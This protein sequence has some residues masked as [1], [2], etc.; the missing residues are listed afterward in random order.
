MRTRRGAASVFALTATV[1]ALTACAPAGGAAV[2]LPPENAV[3]DYQLGAAYEPPDG[4]TVVARDRTADPADGVYSICYLNA[5]QTQ[6]G[7]LADWPG[8][9]ILR[10][11][12]GPLFDPD[13]PGEALLD[14]ST[15]TK[16]QA[17]AD[18]VVPWIRDCAEAGFDAVEFDNLDTYT[19]S[20]G[21]LTFGDN[22]ALGRVLVGA[23]HEA[24]LAA[25]QKNAAEDARV[26]RDEGR[27][28]FAISEECAAYDEC[29]AYLDVYGE[30]VVNVEYGDP[31]AFA[32]ACEGGRMPRASVLRDRDLVAPDDA[33]YVFELC[34]AD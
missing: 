23:A 26:L 3:P 13:W 29:A 30:H 28:D 17:I 21:A 16:R 20:G 15:E 25:A 1:V 5:F 31:V 2:R 10:S 24:G 34:A 8:E 9:L 22:L 14:T 18:I 6:P 27:F 4:V 7:E 19:R 33:A 32:A 12:D 11:A